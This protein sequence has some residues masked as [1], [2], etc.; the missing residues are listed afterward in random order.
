MDFF[1][2]GQIRRYV[3]QFMRVFIGFKYQLGGDTPEQRQV[4][5]MYGD[6][7]RMVASIIKDNS[8]N[9]MSTVPRIAC[10]ITGLELDTA[11]LTDPTFISKVNI[12]ERAYTKNTETGLVEY[13]NI[14]GGN[15]TVERLMPTPFKLTL[16]A[17][18]WTSNT[19]QKLQLLEQILVLFN[20]SLEIQTT[21]NYVDWTSLTV[22]NLDNITFSSRSIP[23]GTDS[24]ID[25]CSIDF[26]TPIYITPPAKVK[27]LGVIRTVISNVFTEQGDVK[28]LTDLAFDL[29]LGKFNVVTGSAR[30]LMFKSQNGQPYDYDITLVNPAD[31]VIS[32]GL[33]RSQKLGAGVDWNHILDIEGGYTAT[34]QV[35]FSQPTGYD[36]IG[37]F[38][39]NP[40]DPTIIV[41]TFD[42][43][44]IPTNSLIPSTI[45]GIDPRGT[46]DAIID[47]Y[48]F[49]P[50]EVFG[51]AE[52]ITLGIR[53]LMLDEVNNS[54]NV[55]QEGYDGPDGWKNVDGSDPV[56]PIN[57]I[58]EWTGTHWVVIFDSATAAVPTYVQN[59]RT[60][61]KYRWTGNEW[62]KAFEGEY[63]PGYWGFKLD[64]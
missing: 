39:V 53:Y 58:I 45:N 62:L 8:E 50:I 6:V 17:D 30:V 1:Y 31:A 35:Y 23:Q 13:K 18:I 28:N 33:E 47:P 16:K 48:K 10:Y 19:D 29:E 2:D 49:N 55:G 61:I 54:Q 22:L 63:S 43:D 59:L 24:E 25:I 4:P 32:Y 21:D 46:I 3:T 20:P 51:S 12:R 64:P 9:K 7:N 56:I 14:Q 15:Y 38:A 36:I 27:K 52:Q 42:Q 34:S 11:R 57:S 40:T 44:T 41:A 5:V 37:T 60:G 26:N